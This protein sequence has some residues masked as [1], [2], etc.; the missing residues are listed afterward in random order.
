MLRVDYDIIIRIN[1]ITNCEYGNYVCYRFIPMVSF[2]WDSG[3]NDLPPIP[4]KFDK[5]T[6]F[7]KLDYDNAGLGLFR[8]RNINL[9][10]FAT[11]GFADLQGTETK[12]Q[13][14]KDGMQGD[15]D[16]I[17]N[18]HREQNIHIPGCRPTAF[19]CL[20]L[21]WRWAD[22]T[23]TIDP[24]VDTVTDLPVLN[25]QEGEPYLVPGQT[26]DVAV[27]KYHPQ[28]AYLTDP[29]ILVNGEIIGSSH[30][31]PM[32]G[33]VNILDSSSHPVVWVMASVSD[34]TVGQF[35]RNGF[36]V[37]DTKSGIPS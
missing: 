3:G 26:I 35:F 30:T 18:V 11:S 14:V 10:A 2:T 31:A 27:V 36:F 34:K 4:D 8:D 37:L 7:Y 28:E 1:P 17:H 25:S 24:L 21:H 13:A 33:P 12:F 9:L 20:H 29:T 32:R 5:F 22:M 19:D 23:P 6:A 15:Y 16:N